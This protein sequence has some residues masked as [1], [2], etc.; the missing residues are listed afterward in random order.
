MVCFSCRACTVETPALSSVPTV[1]LVNSLLC[2][3]EPWFIQA[4]VACVCVCVCCEGM[5]AQCRH[6]SSRR[7][8]ASLKT[9]SRTCMSAAAACK[10]PDC[11]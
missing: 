4:D 2:H 6:A 3:G 8:P 7:L 1:C 9:K 10:V 5:K 11:F